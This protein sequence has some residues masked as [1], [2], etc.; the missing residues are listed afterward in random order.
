MRY[1]TLGVHLTNTCPLACGHCITDSSPSARGELS[2]PQIEE[3]IRSAADYVDGVCLT[4]GEPMLLRDMVLRAIGLTCRLGLR[5]S[6]VTSG[7]W[8]STPEKAAHGVRELAVAGLDKLAISFDRYHLVP[9]HNKMV[10]P[11]TLNY[12]LAAGAPTAMEM[13]VQVCIPRGEDPAEDAAY[14]TAAAAVARFGGRL[15]SSE[16]V[17]FGRAV[18][19]A[20][21]PGARVSDVPA[22]PCGVVGRPILTPEGDFYTCCG[23][24]RGAPASSP[25]RLPIAVAGEVGAALAK[26]GLDPIINTIHTQGPKAMFELLS[27]D[28]RQRVSGKLRDGSMCSLCR[29]ITDDPQA[30]A[31]V[32]AAAGGSE[33]R[34]IALSGVLQVAQD[35]AGVGACHR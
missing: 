18:T 14:K 29:A 2:W 33:L 20:A 12:L 5:A 10:G 15:E 21:R 7:Y 11:Q 22:G 8:A 35:Q 1:N 17:P 31:E 30:V 24:A 34:L 28:A 6:V 25:L 19:I 9:R 32:R 27:A 3:A 4:G 13:V 26:A 16:V 23:P